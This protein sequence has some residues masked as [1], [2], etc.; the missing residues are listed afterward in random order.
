VARIDD[1]DPVS[2][3][4][5]G[6]VRRLVLSHQEPGDSGRETSDNLISSV[7]N[8]PQA[9]RRFG[10]ASKRH[11]KEM[12]LRSFSALEARYSQEQAKTAGSDRR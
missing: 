10:D 2:T 8:M 1:D 3:I 5:S 6:H 11:S 7:N 4:Y 9:G 12:L